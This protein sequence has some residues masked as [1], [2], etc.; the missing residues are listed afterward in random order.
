VAPGPGDALGLA[1]RQQ[2]LE[3][4]GEEVVVVLERVAEERKGLDERAAAGHHL[5]PALGEQVEG[6]EG[7]EHP[8][9]V[10]RAQHGDGAREPDPARPRGDRG[11]HHRRRRGG[12]VGAVVLADHVD[13][14]T[15]LLGP[16]AL[17]DDLAQPHAGVRHDAGRRVRGQLGE[18]RDAHVHDGRG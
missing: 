15:G 1:Q 7:L 2:Q 12:E 3:L 18:G 10:V 5:G 8:H 11:Q 9:R 14:E 4:L 17:L 6:R 16:D 13:V